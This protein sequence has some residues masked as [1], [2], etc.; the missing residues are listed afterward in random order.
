MLA[1]HGY[2]LIGPDAALSTPQPESV[3]DVRAALAEA[4]EA[5]NDCRVQFEYY[6]NNHRVAG[7]FDKA[8]TNQ[9]FA[10]MITQVVAKHG[11]GR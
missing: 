6:A 4:I 3:D 7:K 5:L 10:D 8:A 2:R 9:Q 1:Q 11:V